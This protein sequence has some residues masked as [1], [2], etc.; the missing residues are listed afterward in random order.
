MSY[1][2]KFPAIYYDFANNGEEIRLTN[3]LRGVSIRPSILSQAELSIRYDYKDT[4]KP[5]IIA[6]KLYDDPSMHWLVMEA[7]TVTNPYYD[8]SISQASLNSYVSTKYP[9][10]TLFMVHPDTT[11]SLIYPADTYTLGEY[12]YASD[13]F[14]VVGTVGA[15]TTT[16]V[17][18]TGGSSVD[19]A[20]NGAVI[21]A[22]TGYSIISDY[23]GATK[24]ATLS[25]PLPAAPT[26][27][28][29]GYIVY[30]T[31]IVHAWDL[32]LCKLTISGVVGT[33]SVGNSVTGYSSESTNTVKRVIASS[34]DA[35]HHFANPT[36]GK[37]I[38]PLDSSLNYI[39]EYIFDTSDATMEAAIVTNYS[40]EESQNDAK[41]LIS[42][43]DPSVVQTA[44]SDLI[45]TMRD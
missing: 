27:G 2:S 12:V 3:I 9:G 38:N 30:P 35:L 4:D 45:D 7:N 44:V 24:V 23:V 31:G 32:T 14:I 34:K 25:D 22:G 42:L 40:Y 29:T 20:Y 41:R 28:V 39:E 37:W 10:T 43:L 26:D 13:D 19:D 36:T 11:T 5:E 8:F 15:S 16:T 21:Y 33:F 1:F 18:L 6:N 17:T